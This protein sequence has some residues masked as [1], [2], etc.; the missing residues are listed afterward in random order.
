MS[1]EKRLEAVET[2][3]KDLKEAFIR[4]TVILEQLADVLPQLHEQ[5][6][7][8]TTNEHNWGIVKWVL[9]GSGFGLGVLLLRAFGVL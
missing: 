6:K 8:L 7:R 2:E 4:Q 1:S 5:D 9:G 3:V